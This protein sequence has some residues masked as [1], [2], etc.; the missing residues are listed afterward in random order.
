MKIVRRSALQPEGVLRCYYL[1]RPG[2]CKT[3]YEDFCVWCTT[4]GAR[5]GAAGTQGAFKREGGRG[6][7]GGA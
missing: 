3:H 5:D 4:C 6:G 7:G 1:T 2:W